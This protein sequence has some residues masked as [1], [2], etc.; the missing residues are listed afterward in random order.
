MTRPTRRLVCFVRAGIKLIDL[1]VDGHIPDTPIPSPEHGRTSRRL[2]EEEPES[3]REVGAG[4]M[5]AG[6]PVS[7][8]STMAAMNEG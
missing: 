4:S 5:G 6:D 1:D 7:T 8:K 2:S 3:G